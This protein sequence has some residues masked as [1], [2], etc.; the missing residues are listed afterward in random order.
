ME[1][2]KGIIK[3][4]HDC[5]KIRVKALAFLRC[6]MDKKQFLIAIGV[7]L[8]YLPVLWFLVMPLLT[9][10]MAGETGITMSTRLFEENIFTLEV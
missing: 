9:A 3:L 2:L 8:L 5:D 4:I 10:G 6:T 7:V 1:D